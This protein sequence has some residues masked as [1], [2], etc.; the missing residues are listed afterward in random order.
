MC[1][2]DSFKYYISCEQYLL[3]IQLAINKVEP[4]LQENGNTDIL[5]EHGMKRQSAAPYLFSVHCF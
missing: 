3:N 1:K 4:K 5:Y 2:S